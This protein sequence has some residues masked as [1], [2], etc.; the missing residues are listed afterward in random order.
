MRIITA[1]AS[2]DPTMPFDGP[3]GFATA[4]LA[5]LYFMDGADTLASIANYSILPGAVTTGIATAG[6]AGAHSDATLMTNG[7]VQI[8]GNKYLP[9][10]DIDYSTEWTS[11]AHLAVGQ[12]T[13]HDG[14]TT[15]VSPIISCSGYGA[16][17][18][19]VY[20]T[21]GTTYPTPTTALSPGQRRFEGGVQQAPNSL[22]A[23]A[24]LLY[25]MPATFFHSLKSSKL[26]SRIYVGNTKIADFSLTINPT[27]M[28]NGT[29]I[30]KP[31]V[32]TPYTAYAEANLLVEC[33]GVY[34]RELS[35]ADCQTTADSANAVRLGRGR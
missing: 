11:F 13:T 14:V 1:A 17:G 28:V 12:P 29:P 34:T 8:K 27:L 2:D 30:Q 4:Q 3:R 9:G 31:T 16:R 10:P 25:T 15:W 26:R 5:G 23:P 7:G 6:G 22:A 19:I 32:G 21:I 33:F 18:S 35:D 24:S 20:A